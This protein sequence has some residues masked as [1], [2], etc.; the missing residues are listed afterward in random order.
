MQGRLVDQLHGKIQAF[1]WNE[2]RLEFPR[3]FDMKLTKMEWTLDD[4][5]LFEN[6]FVTKE[7]QE[8]ILE[9][10]REYK[11]MVPSLTG[12]CFMQKPFW[13]ACLR[14][15]AELLEK[16][17]LVIQCSSILGLRFIVIPLVDSGQIETAEQMEVLKTT[18]FGHSDFM[19]EKG[20]QVIFEADFPPKEYLNFINQ[21]PRD[22]FNIN[23]DIG[24][25]ASLGFNSAEEFGVYGSRIANVHVKDRLLGG[26]TVPIGS[27]SA[28]F[29]LVF[30]GL[31]RLGYRGNFILQTA[32]APNRDHGKVL[33]DYASLTKGFLQRHYGP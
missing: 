5:R 30:A 12:D 27:G 10:M 3:A 29:D 33:I 24:N 19:R 8:E 28:N 22:L 17:E 26:T 31:S 14:D 15:R 18:L 6:P 23:Y 1:P 32:R 2:W 13:K 11:V 7:G 20:L 25:S 9:L 21:F 16:L 4:E